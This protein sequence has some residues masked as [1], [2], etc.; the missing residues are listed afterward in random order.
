MS[1]NGYGEKTELFDH[2]V[3][4]AGV[5]GV[6]TAEALVRDGSRVALIEKHPQIALE[7]SAEQ[8]GWGQFG[9]LYLNAVDKKVSEACLH[10]INTIRELYQ[11]YPGNNLT[12]DSEGH[13]VSKNPENPENWYRDDSIFYYYPDSTEVPGLLDPSKRQ[14]WDR[15]VLR[16]LS[17]TQEIA[18]HHW[19][20]NAI[21]LDQSPEAT[22]KIKAAHAAAR[23]WK[24][25]VVQKRPEGAIAHLMCSHHVISPEQLAQ[26]GKTT[27]NLDKYTI[28]ESHDRPMRSTKIL[29]SIYS[30]FLRNGGTEFLSSEVVNYQEM[31]TGLIEIT[32]KTGQKLWARDV[33]FTAG[34]GLES[35]QG[36]HMNTV[37]S[38]LLVVTPAVCPR[39]L[40]HLTPDKKWTINHIHHVD[41]STGKTYSLI[42]NGDGVPPTDQ[43]GIEASRLNLLDLA[44]KLFPALKSIPE[45]DKKIYFGYKNEITQHAG[46][47]NYHFEVE[48]L[49]PGKVLAAVPGKFTLA[50][51]LARH[52]YQI[53]HAGADV[54]T[55][56]GS[57]DASP[58][59]LLDLSSDASSSA[60]S[61]SSPASSPEQPPSLQD[62]YD[63]KAERQI[64]PQLHRQLVAGQLQDPVF[65]S[66]RN[67]LSV[68][69]LQHG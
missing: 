26:N 33:V 23:Q 13:L 2:I 24:R 66:I 64:S 7:A 28:I 49:I 35:I 68:S 32:L 3:V 15:T 36:T 29:Q 67:H 37:M 55:P 63:S 18:Q 11:G 31:D 22:H 53:L 9:A 8:H 44:T 10:N 40:V 57:R 39:N 60:P 5:A 50:P 58:I 59:D 69:S 54:P 1:V 16:V 6:M 17:R 38:P 48:E 25:F 4:G 62:T 45:K 65:R 56:Q 42:G 21:S 20:Q 30:Q 43:Q 12:I 14:D 27:S 46:E 34:G 52:V 61:M 19:R 47:R 51:S 41:S